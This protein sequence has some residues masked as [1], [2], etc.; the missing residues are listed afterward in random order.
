MEFEG[1]LDIKLRSDMLNHTLLFLGYSLGDI[2]VRYMFYKLY[3]LK[4]AIPHR[5]SSEPVAYLVSFGVNDVQEKLLNEWNI[6]IVSLDPI[7]KTKSLL[8]FL[9]KIK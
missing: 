5:K 2:N 4:Q 7:D 6:K 9:K 8:E 3:K 1:A